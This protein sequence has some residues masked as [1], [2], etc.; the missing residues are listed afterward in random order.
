MKVKAASV[1]TPLEKRASRYLL[2]AVEEGSVKYHFKTCPPRILCVSFPPAALLTLLWQYQPQGKS[3]LPSTPL[4][5]Q[6]PENRNSAP[7][8][9]LHPLSPFHSAIPL[10]RPTLQLQPSHPPHQPYTPPA[11]H[12]VNARRFLWHDAPKRWLRYSP[13]GMWHMLN[14]W[15]THSYAVVS[16]SSSLAKKGSATNVTKGTMK[17]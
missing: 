17:R 2:L 4:S 3:K 11:A 5:W 15:R 6:P 1:R 13:D 14:T 10:L 9:P 12:V 16:S 8:S 7:P